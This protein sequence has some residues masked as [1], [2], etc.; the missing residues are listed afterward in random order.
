MNKKKD[1]FY[2]K[3]GTISDERDRSKTLHRLDGPAIEWAEGVKE[4]YVDGKC[5]RIGGPA[6]EYPG[7]TKYWHVDGKYHRIDGPAM[8]LAS[9]NRRWYVD[10]K[11]HRIDGPAV[12]DTDGTKEW[13]VDDE[14]HFKQDF[15]RLIKETNKMS[16]A[17]KLTD[18]RWWVRELGE[19]EI[20]RSHLN[21]EPKKESCLSIAKKV[22]LSI[23][24]AFHML[25]FNR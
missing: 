1:K 21:I 9:G 20:A 19:K 17:M 12:E 24:K 2:Y 18:P 11:C 23:R 8:E 5:H 13:W 3:D 10:G 6:R 7:G 25:P 16:L 4:W 14:Q 15:N 22:F